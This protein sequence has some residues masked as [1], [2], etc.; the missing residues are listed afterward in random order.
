MK[1]WTIDPKHHMSCR[2][3]RSGFSRQLRKLG[4][5]F[6]INSLLTGTSIKPVLVRHIFLQSM[7]ILRF[8]CLLQKKYMMDLFHDSLGFG[9]AK[10]IRRIVGVAHVEDFESITDASKRATCERRALN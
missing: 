4:I 1:S 8:S 3:T 10:M 9:A 5:F 6:T 7:T 2:H